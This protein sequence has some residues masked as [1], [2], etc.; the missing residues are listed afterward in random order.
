[1]G[2]LL[3]YLIPANSIDEAFICGPGAMIDEVEKALLNGGLDPKRIHLERF[4][5]PVSGTPA[6]TTAKG[7]AAQAK[8]TVI[9]DGLKR[10][11]DF[12]KGDPSILD[13]AL[14]QGMDLP[15]S[16][17]GG[18]CN[19]CRCKVLEGEVRMDRNFALEPDEVQAGFVLSCQAH[20]LTDKVV[21][22][23]DDR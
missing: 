1:V 8:I 18:V 21:V 15:Y 3:K 22:S 4:G 23:F 5:V 19:T 12:H 17:K 14:A 16:C 9:Q 7:D 13:V 20:P 10:E 11:V 2:D 6:H